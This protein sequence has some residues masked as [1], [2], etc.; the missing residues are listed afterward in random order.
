MKAAT[1]NAIRRAAKVAARKAVATMEIKA[2]DR[3]DVPIATSERNQ[4]V[5]ALKISRDA[6]DV[7]TAQ[8]LSDAIC[9][10]LD[11]TALSFGAL[12]SVF[13]DRKVASKLFEMY[14]LFYRQL[15]KYSA[16]NFIDLAVA[17][18]DDRWDVGTLDEYSQDAQYA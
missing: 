1:Y 16:G 11:L 8:D 14:G 4:V 6:L 7:M 18:V 12:S 9:E 10:D 15:Y 2:L 3:E 17:A 13:K 5:Q